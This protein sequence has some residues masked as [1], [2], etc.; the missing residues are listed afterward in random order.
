MTMEAGKWYMITTPFAAL[1]DGESRTIND[2]YAVEGFDTNDKLYTLTSSGT[3]KIH[4]WY[5]R[6]ENKGWSTSSFRWE[7]DTEPLTLGQAVYIKKG[8]EG[9]ISLAGKVES[10]T[11]PFGSD[12]GNQWAM[13]GIQWPEKA[14]LNDLV[15]TN[16]TVADKLYRLNADGTFRI[17]HW[18][19]R[20]G[21]AGWSTSSFTLIP[22][23]TPLTI[24]EA[25]Y[26]NKR[27]SSV[28]TV[29]H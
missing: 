5:N 3:F 23:T 14:L 20:N 6:G 10:V 18:V 19:E 8:V 4:H 12:E 15:W 2:V 29:S 16:V 26:I 24:G 13:V 1:A 27:S 25:L 11:V 9:S 21:Q 7:Q 17:H 22:D 28:A